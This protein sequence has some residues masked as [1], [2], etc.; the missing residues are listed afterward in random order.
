M[1]NKSQ[2]WSVLIVF[3]LLPALIAVFFWS[4]RRG[5]AIRRLSQKH[6]KEN[7]EIVLFSTGEG[8][9][10]LGSMLFIAA[11]PSA[12]EDNLWKG[13]IFASV[14][15]AC[16]VI[17]G[18]Y[19]LCGLTKPCLLLNQNEIISSLHGTIPWSNV[20]SVSRIKFKLRLVEI[21]YLVLKLRDINTARLNFIA[22][23]RWFHKFNRSRELKF[24][25][26][27][28]SLPGDY[29]YQYASATIA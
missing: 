13:A 22:P 10:A 8:L 29:V 4:R 21:D 11:T 16:L 5:R 1:E 26:A 9:M 19:A 25:I 24:K 14:G 3:V 27:N 7:G 12:L 17:W 20:E 23:L 15:F 6:I 18:R 2:M 28:M